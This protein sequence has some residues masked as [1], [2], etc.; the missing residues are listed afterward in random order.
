[1]CRMHYNRLRRGSDLY[2]RESRRGLC[3][4]DRFWQHVDRGDT[5]QCWEWTGR[6]DRDGYGQFVLYPPDAL[7]KRTVK[8]SR[9]AYELANGSPAKDNV[10]HR[11]NN[12]PC[13]N[14]E[15]LYDGTLS[16]NALDAVAAGTSSVLRPD[17]P[18]ARGESSGM[19]KLT[20]QAVREI[21][22]RYAA[23]GVTQ[24]QLA[25]VYGVSQSKISDVV[26]RRTW[27]HLP[28]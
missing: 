19:S 22:E 7:K 23:G 4:E 5:N 13:C 28:Q 6:R 3:L 9:L 2:K 24:Q 21:R 12:R 25:D 8:S 16:Q 26:N 18:R 1:M 10:L 17:H 20:N 27:R 11:C 14:P 15:H